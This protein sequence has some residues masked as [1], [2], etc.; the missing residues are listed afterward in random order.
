M[1]A[2]FSSGK[3]FWEPNSRL[4][5]HFWEPFSRLVSNFERQISDKNTFLFLIGSCQIFHLWHANYIMHFYK[6]TI[7]FKFVH[8]CLDA[9]L[10]K[11]IWAFV[12][13]EKFT[14]FFLLS[15]NTSHTSVCTHIPT[16]HAKCMKKETIV[17]HLKPLWK[18]IK[19]V[20]LTAAYLQEAPKESSL[21]CILMKGNPENNFLSCEQQQQNNVVPGW[22]NYSGCSDHPPPPH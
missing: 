19:C 10:L 16:K 2:R 1:M 17:E 22:W 7:L 13:W 12:R 11:Q 9:F 15:K 20:K 21:I 5:M 3:W 6:G 4:V 14:N 18:R 8:H